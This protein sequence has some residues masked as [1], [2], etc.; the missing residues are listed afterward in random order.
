MTDAR[1]GPQ[2][3]LK[4]AIDNSIIATSRISDAR[5]PIRYVSLSGSFTAKGSSATLKAMFIATDYLGVTW[6]IDNVVVTPA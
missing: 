1:A 6:G 4:F 5:S 3:F 2:T